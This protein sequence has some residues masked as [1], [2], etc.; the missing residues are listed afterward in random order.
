MIKICVLSSTI[1]LESENGII[2]DICRLAGSNRSAKLDVLIEVSVKVPADKD[3][4]ILVPRNACLEEHCLTR[5]PANV[6]FLF[7]DCDDHFSKETI[8]KVKS[9]MC[10]T[11][12][13]DANATDDPRLPGWKIKHIVCKDDS[14]VEDDLT[15]SD[16]F[17]IDRTPE[18]WDDL[19]GKAFREGYALR[20]QDI[21]MLL[22]E[23][24]TIVPQMVRTFETE[25]V[26][27]ES[28]NPNIV[29]ILN[30][31]N[32]TSITWKHGPA[33]ELVLIIN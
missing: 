2:R 28:V 7:E 6:A 18:S 22:K 14:L 4:I 9:H 19:F 11:Y 32:I 24:L 13:P 16:Y 8:L 23:A 17:A 21:S 5:V 29:K 10:F 31:Y 27:C 15:I 1:F 30:S 12:S 25:R 3:Y 26:M 33:G 20:Q